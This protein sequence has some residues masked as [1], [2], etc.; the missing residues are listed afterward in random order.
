MAVDDFAVALGTVI[1]RWVERYPM[2]LLLWVTRTCPGSRLYGGRFA[3]PSNGHLAY[4]VTCQVCAHDFNDD[5]TGV[6]PRHRR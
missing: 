2:R 5:G 1:L 3:L 4:G 6:P